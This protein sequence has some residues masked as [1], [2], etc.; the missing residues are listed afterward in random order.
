MVVESAPT[1]R[2]ATVH[3][4]TVHGL[5]NYYI[6]TTTGTRALVHNEYAPRYR[7]IRLISVVLLHKLVSRMVCVRGKIMLQ[8]V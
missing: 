1:G 2:T 7:M 5:T 6:T 4:L 3:N 8:P